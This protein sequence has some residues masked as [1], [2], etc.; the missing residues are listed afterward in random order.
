MP[1]PIFLITHG[2]SAVDPVCDVTTVLF[3]VPKCFSGVWLYKSSRG[4]NETVS[5]FWSGF[6]VDVVGC[7]G[8]DGP[9]DKMIFNLAVIGKLRQKFAAGFEMTDIII[10][11]KW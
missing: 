11:Q 6:S 2:R 7:V 1:S 9:V 8:D 5:S 4:G 3:S 10:L